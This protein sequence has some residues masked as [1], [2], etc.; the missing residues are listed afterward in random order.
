[1]KPGNLP[2]KRCSLSLL[3][4]SASLLP[5]CAFHFI[6]LFYNFICLTL[7]WEINAVCFAIRRLY[8]ISITPPLQDIHPRLSVHKHS[9]YQSDFMKINHTLFSISTSAHWHSRYRTSLPHWHSRYSTSL[10]HRHNAWPKFQ[11]RE[12]FKV[13]FVRAMHLIFWP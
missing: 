9:S 12:I 10:Q 7:Y 4:P 2:T 6:L 11:K 8:P 1:M 13:N 5:C 3:S